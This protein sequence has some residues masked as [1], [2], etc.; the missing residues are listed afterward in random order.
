MRA[1]VVAR[2][3]A[4][5]PAA[6]RLIAEVY[7][8]HYSARIRAFPATLVA[9]ISDDGAVLSAAGLRLAA[10]GFFSEC[11]LEAPV[12]VVLSALSRYPVRREKI[13]EVTS[14]AS[15]SPHTV[16]SFLRKIIACG[17]AA[18]FEW[19][20]FTA[21][22]PL[23][24]LLERMSLPLVPL[25]AADRSRVPNPDAWGSYYALA[26]SVYAV[27]RDVVGARVGRDFGAAAHV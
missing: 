8:R 16:G 14:L 24:A 6:E 1:A 10:D 27:H 15:R 7:A 2:D 4:L 25:A 3:H 5:R 13:L 26:P 20:F 12:D 11:Y 9:M 19:A 23:K 18:G 17:E 22:A 21:T